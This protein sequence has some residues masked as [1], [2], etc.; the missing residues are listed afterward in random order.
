MQMITAKE[1]IK[2]GVPIKCLHAVVVAVH[3]TNCT[4]TVERF[5]IYFRSH[6][7]GKEYKHI[8]LGMYVQGHF[9]ALGI[10]RDAGLQDKKAVYSKLSELIFEFAKCYDQSGHILNEV[11]FGNIITHDQHSLERLF[12]KIGSVTIHGSKHE[13][14]ESHVERMAKQL[15]AKMGLPCLKSIRLDA[16]LFP[17][18]STRSS[19]SKTSIIGHNTPSHTRTLSMG[20]PP[21]RGSD[22]SIKPLTRS[23]P[24]KTNR[25]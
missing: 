20:P 19:R 23:K 13:D 15:R 7:A 24:P 9:G 6:V 8:V 4:E 25:K 12:S 22:E 14:I 2:A 17:A 16:Y 21:K 1:I 10:S 11:K 5:P 18:N 3:F